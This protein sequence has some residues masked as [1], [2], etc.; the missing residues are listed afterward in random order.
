MRNTAKEKA[1]QNANAE[2][3]RQGL[4]SIVREILSE[5][6]PERKQNE[7]AITRESMAKNKGK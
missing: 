2:R 1:Y 3:V 4:K 5:M 7:G 6:W